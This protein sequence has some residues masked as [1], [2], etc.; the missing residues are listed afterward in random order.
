MS[1]LVLVLSIGGALT[2]QLF[3]DARCIR[4]L[5]S[6]RG[7]AVLRILWT[8]SLLRSR[9]ERSYW[10]RYRAPDGR[11]ER[12][13][14]RLVNPFHGAHGVALEPA[15]AAESSSA[16]LPARLGRGGFVVVC[17]LAG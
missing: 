14:C 16:P 1:A 4:A 17:A 3:L 11:I 9:W 7:W 8:P 15:V 5:A 12:R 13:L 10:L 2:L 6:E